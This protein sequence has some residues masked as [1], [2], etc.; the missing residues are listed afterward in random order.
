MRSKTHQTAQVT[1]SH[2]KRPAPT[3][4]DATTGSFKVM[5]KPAPYR[6]WLSALAA[7]CLLSSSGWAA[8]SQQAV[9]DEYRSPQGDTT[10]ALT[11]KGQS[12]NTSSQFRAGDHILMVDTS[13]SQ[14]GDVRTRSLELVRSYIERLTDD[15]RVAI[16]ATDVD[17]QILSRGLVTATG[18]DAKAALAALE[19]RVPMGATNLN[20]ALETALTLS[21]DSRSTSVLLIGD[22][23]STGGLVSAARMSTL[24]GELRA[25]KMPVSCVALGRETDAQLMGVL[26]NQTGGIVQT[27]DA[28]KETTASDQA[29][30]LVKAARVSVFYPT[31]IKVTGRSVELLPGKALPVRSDRSTIYIGRGEMAEGTR[32]AASD[33]TGMLTWTVQSIRSNNANAFL[34]PVYRN[35][36]MDAGLSVPFAGSPVMASVQ[37]DF[38][39]QVDALTSLSEAAVATK[40]LDEAEELALA[41]RQ[42]D[43]ENKKGESL[44]RRIQKLKAE[45]QLAQAPTP[46]PPAADDEGLGTDDDKRDLILDVLSQRQIR[47]QELAARVARDIESARQVQNDDPE[48]ALTILKSALGAVIAAD[49]DPDGR[50]ELRKRVQ[51][52]TRDV[53]NLKRV[54]DERRIRAAER[55]AE[56]IAREAVID[57]MEISEEE[58]ESLIDQVRGLLNEARQ[59]EAFYEDTASSGTTAFTESVQRTDAYEEAERT[60]RVALSKNPG[61]GIATAAVFTSEAAGQLHKAE[62]LRAIRADR[63]LEVLY[64]VERSHVPFPDEPPIRWPTAQEW[65]LLTEK[66]KKWDNVDLKRYSPSEQAIQDALD[67]TEG[68]ME[69]LDIPLKE[70]LEFLGTLYGITIIID[71]VALTDEGIDSSEVINYQLGEIPLR[72][73]LKIIL[74]PF[75][76]TY[77]IENDVM[78]ITTIAISEERLTTRVYPVGDLVIAIPPPGSLGGGFGGGGAGGGFGGGLQGGGGGGF[79]GGGQGGFG[80][81][82]QGGFGG[83]GV[84][85]GA[86]SIPPAAINRANAKRRQRQPGKPAAPALQPV[87]DPELKGLLDGIL[88]EKTSAVAQPKGQAFA[89]VKDDFRLD[90]DAIQ[91]L[92]KKPTTAR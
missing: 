66:R 35:A 42:L 27:A 80:G 77:I 33:A 46:Q 90:N 34:R 11:L 69:F 39:Q 49:V 70:A 89:Q 65:F 84:G 8:D 50:E 62:Q 68:Q 53:T 28:Q 32:I 13:A 24:V 4:P 83:G 54:I 72:S 64:Q 19:N 63:F 29:E 26:A 85:G 6:R 7:A 57:E 10:F 23:M 15:D 47:L 37:A 20:R 55:R 14:V 21:D 61:N 73:T 92:K 9:V 78:V 48:G 12:V 25:H 17:S 40:S 41:V 52:V 51:A 45:D 88:G 38:I 5:G 22:G 60:A 36:K 44:L 87:Q 31:N 56:A 79:G 81:G 76:L 71:E 18:M 2:I 30:G 86:F 67:K 58:L 74:E 43:P 1:K 82:G 16:V 91:S 3:D 59:L 75:G